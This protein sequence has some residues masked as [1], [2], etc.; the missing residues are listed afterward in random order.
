MM[1]AKYNT[2]MH[3][4]EEAMKDRENKEIEIKM[5]TRRKLALTKRHRIFGDFS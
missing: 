4:L 3:K 1:Q 2:L 5:L